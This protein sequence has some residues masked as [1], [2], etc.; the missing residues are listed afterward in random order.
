MAPGRKTDDFWTELKVN[1]PTKFRPAAV[2]AARKRYM[3]VPEYCR[4][5]LLNAIEVDGVRLD[6]E[7]A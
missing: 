4:A 1:L 3:S 5:V 7:V 2:Q 6:R